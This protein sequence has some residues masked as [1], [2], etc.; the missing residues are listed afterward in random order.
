M[1]E[2][3]IRETTV[4]DNLIRT[5]NALKGL[6]MSLRIEPPEKLEV[7]FDD[8]SPKQV[9][10]AVMAIVNHHPRGATHLGPGTVGLYWEPDDDP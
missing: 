7:S 2:T 6:P 5:V 8:M 4:C 9:V 10:D 3:E 1:C